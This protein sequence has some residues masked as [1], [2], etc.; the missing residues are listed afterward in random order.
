M[1]KIASVALSGWNRLPLLI[2]LF[3]LSGCQPAAEQ[4]DTLS[5]PSM[6]KAAQVSMTLTSTATAELVP[7]TP[8]P[9]ASSEP[10]STSQA[11]TATSES[12]ETVLPAEVTP[13]RAKERDDAVTITVVY[14]NNLYDPRL[15]TAWGF[16]CLVE[17]GEKIILFDT[18][19][20]GVTLLRN[21]GTL[22]IAP[23]SIDTIVLSHIHGDHTGGLANIFAMGVRP[24]VYVPNSFPASFKSRVR[25][26]TG[27]VEVDQAAEISDGAYTTGEMGS[28]IVE[29]ALVL[30][31]S[32]GLVIVTGCAHPGVVEM[33]R[34]AKEIG[35]DEP[36]L[37]LGGFHLSGV[38]EERIKEIITEFQRLGVQKVA[39][40]HCTGDKAIALF[41]EAY[42]EDF[43]QN[44]VGQ[45]MRIPP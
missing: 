1:R 41:R 17:I 2:L 8:S 33:V 4:V 29:Q 24:T 6:Q 3:T 44:G 34:R 31:T 11:P 32:R 15:Q 14:D 25:A 36:Y 18:G 10:V 37:V 21:M 42:G 9:T 5:L 19:G 12:S 43:I 26:D 30:S 39:P 40:C 28:G 13:T 35:E 27:L 20:D 16:A 23:T 38:S 45:M 7:M 22:G